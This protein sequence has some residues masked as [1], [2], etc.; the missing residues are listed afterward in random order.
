MSYLHIFFCFDKL[1]KFLTFKLC[2]F[3]LSFIHFLLILLSLRTNILNI[4]IF[5]NYFHCKKWKVFKMSR[6]YSWKKLFCYKV[7][8]KF[9]N[10]LIAWT[11]F[12]LIN[13]QLLSQHFLFK[14]KFFCNGASYL[15][16]ILVFISVVLLLSLLLL[17]LLLLLIVGWISCIEEVK[18]IIF[19]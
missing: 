11:Q 3:I 10:A 15:L 2:H 19:C 13:L 16:K 6:C 5:E 18:L 14:K 8:I 7:L 4:K 12:L 1:E 9:K 17:S